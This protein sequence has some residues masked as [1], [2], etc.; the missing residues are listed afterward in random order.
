MLHLR[1]AYCNVYR[2]YLLLFLLCQ[3]LGGL[4]FASELLFIGSYNGRE[5]LPGIFVFDLDTANGQLTKICS[6]ANVLNPAYIALSASGNT[7]YACTEA[8]VPGG[9]KLR[10]YKYE[11]RALSLLSEVSSEGEN[12]VY[13]TTTADEQYLFTANYTGSTVAAFPLHNGTIS[14]ATQVLM[15]VDSSINAE[16][17]ECAHPHAVVL[18]PDGRYLYAPDL[19]ADKIR[20]FSVDTA[21]EQP[22][23]PVVKSGKVVTAGSGPR[24]LVFSPNSSYAYCTEEMAGAVGV[25]R[26]GEGGSLDSCQRIMIHKRRKG[27][28]F[29]AAEIHLSPDSRFLYAANRGKENNIAIMAIDQATGKVE[30]V[31]YC[32]VHGDHPRSFAIDPSGKFLL[33]ANQVSG[34]VVVFRRNVNTGLLSYTGI[35][36]KIPGASCVRFN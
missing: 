23:R 19:G 9:G 21:L 14:K 31:G 27:G 1:I 10:S 24:H 15:F 8:R 35:K 33:V 2:S 11:N 4:A 20:C 18:S 3:L 13:L 30:V 12:P 26:V 17:Q 28:Q 5:T 6:V 16:R 36:I 29:S 22:M 7:I 32:P 25:Y 34:N